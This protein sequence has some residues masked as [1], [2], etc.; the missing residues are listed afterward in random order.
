M[1]LCLQMLGRTSN[2]GKEGQEQQ[3]SDVAM[4]CAI[5]LNDGELAEQLADRTIAKVWYKLA[6]IYHIKPPTRLNSGQM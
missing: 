2:G 6:D 3:V 5:K 1:K 4:R